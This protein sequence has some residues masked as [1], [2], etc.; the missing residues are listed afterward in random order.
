MVDDRPHAVVRKNAMRQTSANTVNVMQGCTVTHVSPALVP[1]SGISVGTHRMV[2]G[3]D[4]LM[5]EGGRGHCC[6]LTHEEPQP[7]L[8]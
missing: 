1:Y 6:V 3:P 5:V 7:D 8:Q 4:W 2:L